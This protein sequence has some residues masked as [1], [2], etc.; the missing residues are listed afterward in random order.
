[1]S[2]LDNLRGRIVKLPAALAEAMLYHGLPAN[3]PSF[4]SV[5]AQSEP[6]LIAGASPPAADKDIQ[7]REGAWRE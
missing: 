2:D 7:Q 5:L 3:D 4:A 1:M 6:V